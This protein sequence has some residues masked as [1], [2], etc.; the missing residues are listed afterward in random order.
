MMLVCVCVCVCVDHRLHNSRRSPSF[1]SDVCIEQRLFGMR[2][3]C[4][5]PKAVFISE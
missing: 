2:I 3:Y 1:N 4:S 5:E